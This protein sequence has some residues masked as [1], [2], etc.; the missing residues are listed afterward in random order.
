MT[1]DKIRTSS[2]TTALHANKLALGFRGLAWSAFMKRLLN[3][4]AVSAL[5]H[6][7]LLVTFLVLLEYTI[8]YCWS[9]SRLTGRNIA[10]VTQLALHADAG[11]AHFLL[12]DNSAQFANEFVQYLGSVELQQGELIAEL[13]PKPEGIRR[14]VST[15]TAMILATDQGVLQR[16]ETQDNVEVVTDIVAT[17]EFSITQLLYDDANNLVIVRGIDL[18]AWNAETGELV[19]RIRPSGHI[20]LTLGNREKWLYCGTI[21]GTILKIDRATGELDREFMKFRKRVIQISVSPSGKHLIA[22][23]DQGDVIMISMDDAEIIWRTEGAIIVPPIFNRS[24]DK[25][26]VAELCH[27]KLA[28]ME[29]T[30]GRKLKSLPHDRALGMTFANDE[31]LIV[32][33]KDGCITAWNTSS[34]EIVWCTDFQ[35]GL[36]L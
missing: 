16:L 20:C 6:S 15:D 13:L 28:I 24:G 35:T 9:P 3:K 12:G 17:G 18:S 30:T 27:Q 21:S 5:L 2:L 25:I 33:G 32:W 1:C 36:S 10:A 23:L 4:I 7:F 14:I 31:T 29:A 26:V 22:C 11:S 19:W 8:I 34:G